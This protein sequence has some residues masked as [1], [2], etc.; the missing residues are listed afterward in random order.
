MNW[1]KLL[2]TFLLKQLEKYAHKTITSSLVGTR[3][4]TDTKKGEAW[5]EYVKIIGESRS[6][7]P[8]YEV[9]KEIRYVCVLDERKYVI[10]VPVGFTTDLASVPRI[11]WSLFPPN[12]TYSI[13]AIIHDYLTGSRL[14]PFDVC[15]RIFYHAMKWSEPATP[16]RTRVLFYYVVRNFGESFVYC[17]HTPESIR[18]NRRLAGYCRKQLAEKLGRETCRYA[19]EGLCDIAEAGNDSEIKDDNG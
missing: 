17:K 9:I 1:K 7:A 6:G 10:C 4:A 14:Y 15:D 11:F 2:L 3:A 18:E 5:Y 8:I 13:P 12:C 19:E 16:F